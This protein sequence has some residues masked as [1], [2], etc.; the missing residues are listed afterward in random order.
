MSPQQLEQLIQRAVTERLPKVVEKTMLV[1]HSS[2]SGPLPMAAETERYEG[3][4]PGFTN[5]WVTMSE[6]EQEERFKTIRR[7]DWM[8]IVYKIASLLVG[9]MLVSGLLLG[10]FYLLNQG[11]SVEGYSSIAIGAGALLGALVFGRRKKPK[12]KTE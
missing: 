9:F 3:L 11:K 5:R 8:E 6:K 7:R 1:Q 10:G 12:E 2:Y 4:L